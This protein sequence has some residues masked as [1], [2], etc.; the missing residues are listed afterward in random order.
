MGF[1]EMFHSAKVERRTTT[2]PVR[3]YHNGK[4]T[5]HNWS[6]TETEMCFHYILHPRKRLQFV[7]VLCNIWF[8]RSKKKATKHYKSQFWACSIRS[9]SLYASWGK[10]NRHCCKILVHFWR[11]SFVLFGRQS[12]EKHEP[13]TVREEHIPPKKNVKKI[14]F[15]AITKEHIMFRNREPEAKGKT[16]KKEMKK[17]RKRKRGNDWRR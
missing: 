16:I 4:R 9:V 11:L 15:E 8:C 10:L 6:A 7:S 5:G 13:T 2:T 17:R 1:R 3:R 14:Y 12:L